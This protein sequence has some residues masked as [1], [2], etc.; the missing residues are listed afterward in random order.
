MPRNNYDN[1]IDNY[2][3]AARQTRQSNWTSMWLQNA[4]PELRTARMRNGYWS[5]LPMENSVSDDVF[6]MGCDGG[7]TVGP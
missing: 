4:P 5:A 6:F 2:K 3:H 7:T 1:I